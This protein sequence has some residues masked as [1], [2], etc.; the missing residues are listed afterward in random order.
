MKLSNGADGYDTPDNTNKKTATWA[1]VL[2]EW[3]G[4]RGSNARP[5]D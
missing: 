1:V 2:F 5:P 4:V 3:W